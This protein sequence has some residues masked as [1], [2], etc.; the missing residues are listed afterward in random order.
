MDVT[1]SLPSCSLREG[2][3]V[4]LGSFLL[5]QGKW[6]KTPKAFHVLLMVMVSQWV[7]HYTEICSMIFRAAL[8]KI[9]FLC[10]HNLVT[11]TLSFF[12]FLLAH[13]HVAFVYQHKKKCK[14]FVDFRNILSLWE[15]QNLSRV[16]NVLRHSQLGASQSINRDL[17]GASKDTVNVWRPPKR[18]LVTTVLWHS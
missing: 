11:H 6:P 9:F 7:Y 3:T 16:T 4:A 8:R 17:T 1:G 18:G 2:V 10:A 12:S 14:K 5:C 15:H 13:I